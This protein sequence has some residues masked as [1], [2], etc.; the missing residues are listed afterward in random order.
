MIMD[1]HSTGCAKPTGFAPPVATALRPC[2]GESCGGSLGACLVS[3][4]SVNAAAQGGR[5]FAPKGHRAVAT[6]AAS[7]LAG[8]RNPWKQLSSCASRPGGQCRELKGRNTTR[9]SAPLDESAPKGPEHISPGRRCAAGAASLCP[10]LVCC[11]PVR[12]ASSAPNGRQAVPCLK[13]ASIG[14]QAA[15]CRWIRSLSS[16]RC[17]EG[18]RKIT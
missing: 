10:G 1:S 15:T 7:R 16:R 12:G 6:G 5:L 17:P 13:L 3:V 14:R 8:R 9:P 18:R 2:R 4:R 11:C